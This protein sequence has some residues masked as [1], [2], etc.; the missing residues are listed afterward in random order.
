MRNNKLVVG[1][2]VGLSIG[3]IFGVLFAPKK[4]S[5]LKKNV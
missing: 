5:K 3:G 2:L 1:L 4:G